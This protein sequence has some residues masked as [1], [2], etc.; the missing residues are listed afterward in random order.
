MLGIDVT[1][2]S[3]NQ[4]KQDSKLL[5]QSLNIIQQGSIEDI[6]NS[7]ENQKKIVQ[8][9]ITGIQKIK[10]EYDKITKGLQDLTI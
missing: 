9:N 5:Q 8:N 10:V 6:N 1:T 2:E 4:A 7:L 3:I